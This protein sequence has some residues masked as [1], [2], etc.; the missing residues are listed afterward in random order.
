MRTLEAQLGGIQLDRHV[1][2]G[3]GDDQAVLSVRHFSHLLSIANCSFMTRLR[4]SRVY[5]DCLW[6]RKWSCAFVF[7]DEDVG[8]SG[9]G[10]RC[11]PGL[12]GLLLPC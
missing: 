1:G 5:W 9:Q 6:E 4:V 3:G 12:S 7:A 2:G 10:G 11:A 8:D